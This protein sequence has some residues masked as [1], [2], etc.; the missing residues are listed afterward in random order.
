MQRKGKSKFWLTLGLLFIII[1]LLCFLCP[2]YQEKKDEQIE[3]HKLEQFFE[4]QTPYEEV[5]V[6]EVKE[7]NP[8]F[9]V[10]E[11]P[12]IHLKK[13]LYAINHPYNDVDYNIMI[14]K[15]SNMPDQLQ[16]NFMVA[17][18]SGTGR[19]AYFNQLHELELGDF[20]SIYYHGVQYIYQV[21]KI[22]HVEKTGFVSIHR[23]MNE[24]TLTMITC[25]QTN[26]Q[27]VIIATQ[28]EKFPYQ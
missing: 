20:A 5:K 8:Y 23:N 1:G 26:Q 3:H 21:T 15:E 22:Y 17:A 25:D 16:G 6:E 10:I 12:K 11:I 19:N 28:V 24:T 9:A 7:D 2:F 14:L 4:E 13:G 27:M 18:H